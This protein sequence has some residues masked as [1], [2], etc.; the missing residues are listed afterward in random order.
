MKLKKRKIAILIILLIICFMMSSFSII[1]ENATV[2]ENKEIITSLKT[3]TI[4]KNES[5]ELLYDYSTDL[6]TIKKNDGNIV[7]YSY[8]VDAQTDTTAQGSI[9]KELTSNLVVNFVDKK[10]NSFTANSYT[11]SVSQETHVAYKTQNGLLVEYD[12]SRK[13]EQFKISVLYS[14][15]DD[16]FTAEI[17]FDQIKEYD[18]NKII[19]IKLM[20]YFG[21]GKKDEK[22]FLLLP[23]GSGAIVDFKADKGWA[24]SYYKQVYGKDPSKS[25]YIFST[26]DEQIYLPVFGICKTEE[27]YIGM[28]EQCDGSAYIEGIQAG[29]STDYASAS[30]SFS[31]RQLDNLKLYDK[32]GTE[33]IITFESKK[34]TEVNPIIRYQFTNKEKSNLVGM[35]EIYRNRLIRKSN[36]SQLKNNSNT[37]L[38]LDIYGASEKKESVLGFLIDKVVAVTTINDLKDITKVLIDSKIDN[39]IIT[40]KYFNEKGTGGSVSHKFNID[41]NIGGKV[42]FEKYIEENKNKGIEVFWGINNI[43]IKRGSFM[44]WQFNCAAT[45]MIQT[46]LI[47]YEYKKSINT[48]NKKEKLYFYMMPEK[49]LNILDKKSY[50]SFKNTGIAGLSFSKTSSVLYSDN[51]INNYSSRERTIA[52]YKNLY[53]QAIDNNINLLADGANAYS[54]PYSRYI[55]NVPVSTS[56]FDIMTQPVPFFQ[57]VFHGMKEFSSIPINTGYDLNTAFLQC[58]LTG[59]GLHYSLTGQSSVM[60]KDT[61]LNYLLSTNYKDWIIDITKNYIIFNSI[62][63]KLQNEFIIGYEQNGYVEKIIYQSGTV[64]AINKGNEKAISDGN[65]IEGNSYISY[66]QEVS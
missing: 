48:V 13:K 62:H 43:N 18:T 19:E 21:A 5:L 23:D 64:I 4:L 60:L 42:D 55:A 59:T 15:D 16:G 8:P 52:Y 31:Y 54:I 14:L 66:L 25:D 58:I 38:Y 30:S 57:I 26:S 40:L 28:I 27:A 33:K 12:F 22:G 61:Q 39:T 17:L 49:L 20:P 3:E 10:N 29:K 24:D 36:L 1:A 6:I 2:N 50:E 53:Q 32:Y 56:S 41:G 9:K 34:V 11:S 7:W 37:P 44:W 46:K 45:N 35:A 65:T 47:E 51:K 63:K